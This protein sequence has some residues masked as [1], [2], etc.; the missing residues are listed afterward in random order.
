M[1]DARKESGADA[2]RACSL[3]DN[4]HDTLITGSFSI[5]RNF[6]I[7]EYGDHIMLGNIIVQ[8]RLMSY[9]ER[10]RE[11]YGNGRVLCE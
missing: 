8:L 2:V 5:Y 9:E 6:I 10:Y 11:I 4:I 7:I 1:H 3:V